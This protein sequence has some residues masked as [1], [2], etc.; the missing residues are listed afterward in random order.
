ML[1]DAHKFIKEKYTDEMS[2][3]KRKEFVEDEKNDPTIMGHGSRGLA[4]P[5]TFN[6]WEGVQNDQSGQKSSWFVPIT[7]ALEEGYSNEKYIHKNVSWCTT[8]AFHARAK[9]SNVKNFV[10]S[11]FYPLDDFLMTTATN[12]HLNSSD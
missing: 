6:N 12:Y 3:S 11:E 4:D 8:Y 2:P 5:S 10:G 9:Q 7:P 1:E